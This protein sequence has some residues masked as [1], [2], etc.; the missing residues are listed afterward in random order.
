MNT[1]G[2][3]DDAVVLMLFPV[4]E[5]AITCGDVGDGNGCDA[6]TTVALR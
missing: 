3:D 1:V 6:F 2:D 4:M 5:V